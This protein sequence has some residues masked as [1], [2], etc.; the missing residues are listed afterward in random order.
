MPPILLPKTVGRLGISVFILKCWGNGV[1]RR[2]HTS[3]S[4]HIPLQPRTAATERISRVLV[5]IGSQ[6]D[7]LQL[8][9]VKGH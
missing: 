9:H 5:P 4:T 6:L 3:S 2:V 8:S 7:R 1:I